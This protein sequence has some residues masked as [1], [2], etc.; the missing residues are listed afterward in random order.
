ME[1]SHVT[2]G[3]IS[4]IFGTASNNAELLGTLMYYLHMSQKIL[5]GFFSS[6][7]CL[8]LPYSLG[9]LKMHLC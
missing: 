3:A 1:F 9:I 4:L 8:Y 6:L 5:L 2:P 7:A